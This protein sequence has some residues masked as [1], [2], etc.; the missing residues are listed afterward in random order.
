VKF[1]TGD[2]VCRRRDVFDD[3]SPFMFGTVTEVYSDYDSPYGPYPE[4]YEVTWDGGKV[5]RSYLP[6]GL[7]SVDRTTHE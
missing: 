2:L 1:K 5:V 4:L 3:H 7:N 6:H